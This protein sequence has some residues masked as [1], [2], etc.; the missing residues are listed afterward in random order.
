MSSTA[1]P[2][3]SKAQ[4]PKRIPI[5]E[6]L[7]CK[8]QAQ[9]RRFAAASIDLPVRTQHLTALE[10]NGTPQGSA[11]AGGTKQIKVGVGREE[12]RAEQ[13]RSGQN[14][15]GKSR[16][17]HGGEAGHGRERRKGRAG[18]GNG[19]ERDMRALQ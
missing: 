13:S 11:D 9:N 7:M 18:Q 14:K 16:V 10:L 17:G 5:L 4:L 3:T 8:Q 15:A 6:K 12:M 2:V 19:R 1:K